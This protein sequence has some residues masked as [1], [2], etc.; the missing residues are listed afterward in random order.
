MAGNVKVGGNV[1]ATHTGVEGAGTVTLSNVTASALKMSSSG[2][3][4]TDSAG[5]AVLSESSGTVNINKGTLG[6][7]VVFPAGHIL[8]IVY[9]QKKRHFSYFNL[10]LDGYPRHGSKWIWICLF[11]NYYPNLNI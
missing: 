5:N 1:I 6:S 9:N 11:G 8:Q 2:N 7:S 3:T 10:N 4:I